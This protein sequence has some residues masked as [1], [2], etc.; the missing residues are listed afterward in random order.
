MKIEAEILTIF[1][2]VLFAAL[3]VSSYGLGGDFY[4]VFFIVS[5]IALLITVLIDLI[6]RIEIEPSSTESSNKKETKT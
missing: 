4:G 6:D 3:G 1:V 2:A 5:Y